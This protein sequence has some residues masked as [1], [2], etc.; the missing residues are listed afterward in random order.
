[1]PDESLRAWAELIAA[2]SPVPVPDVLDVGTGTGM[3]AMALA[4]W[5]V[6][7]MVI[8][9]DASPAMLAHSVRHEKVRYLTADAAALPLAGARFDLVLLLA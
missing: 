7:R 5:I 4:R 3:F 8:A 9:V 1:M 2:C 6:V